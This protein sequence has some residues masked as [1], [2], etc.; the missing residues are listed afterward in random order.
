MN[1]PDCKICGYEN[2]TGRAMCEVCELETDERAADDAAYTRE[3]GDFYD[4]EG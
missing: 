4:E 2:D 3:A 1:H